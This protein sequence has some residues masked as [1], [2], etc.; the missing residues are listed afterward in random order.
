MLFPV[1]M[2]RKVFTLSSA[3]ISPTRTLRPG[4]T[5]RRPSSCLAPLQHP[6]HPSPALLIKLP[7]QLLKPGKRAMVHSL[8][9]PNGHFIT[10]DA[11]QPALEPEQRLK[12]PVITSSALGPIPDAPS[13]AAGKDIAPRREVKLTDSGAVNRA[14]HPPLLSAIFRHCVAQLD[15][16]GLL[17]TPTTCAIGCTKA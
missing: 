3:N 15:T 14:M 1:Q 11:S 8:G 16:L 5:L 4:G 12:R 17:R 6:I 2:G 13:L 7:I 10:L 9:A